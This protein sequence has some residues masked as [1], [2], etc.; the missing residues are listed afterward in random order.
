M[1]MT[2]I[3]NRKGKKMV[4]TGRDR[5]GVVRSGCCIINVFTY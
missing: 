4:S 5:E 1:D 2:E 3:K